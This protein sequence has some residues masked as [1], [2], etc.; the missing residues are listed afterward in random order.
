M[1]DGRKPRR[2]KAYGKVVSTRYLGEFEAVSQEG[3]REQAFASAAG[4]APACFRC[5]CGAKASPSQVVEVQVELALD[6]R[7]EEW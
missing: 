3:A 1:T 4:K 6:A 7:G 2:Y 5:R